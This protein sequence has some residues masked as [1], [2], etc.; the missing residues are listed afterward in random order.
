MS[1]EN[2]EC[3]KRINELNCSNVEV[4]ENLRR[5]HSKNITNLQDKMKKHNETIYQILQYN[6]ALV[7]RK[8]GT[9]M[10]LFP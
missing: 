7:E 1:G 3:K 8:N 5:K 2:E 4:W 6:K 10:G 9:L